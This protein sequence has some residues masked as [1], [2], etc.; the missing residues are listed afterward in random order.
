MPSQ[1]LFSEFKID[2]CKLQVDFP[3]FDSKEHPLV[4]VVVI[5][6]VECHQSSIFYLENAFRGGV[7]GR[8]VS[9]GRCKKKSQR[10]RLYYNVMSDCFESFSPLKKIWINQPLMS[11]SD[12]TH[13]P[14][15]GYWF[16]LVDCLTIRIIM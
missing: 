14:K 7:S 4:K 12:V 9:L 1:Q 3:G 8:E 15:T 16:W 2:A 13:Y 5:F 6:Y 10:R 11:S